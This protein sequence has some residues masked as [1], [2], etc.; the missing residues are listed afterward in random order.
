MDYYLNVDENIFDALDENNKAYEKLRKAN[1]LI[2]KMRRKVL[3]RH[4]ETGEVIDLN[5]YEIY[6]G[7]S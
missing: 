1:E 2:K 7:E 4:K 3:Y 6:G 5:D